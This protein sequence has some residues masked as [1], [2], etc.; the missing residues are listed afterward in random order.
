MSG[1]S[2]PPHEEPI[3]TTVDQQSSHEDRILALTQ[4]ALELKKKISAE[5]QRLKKARSKIPTP[6]SITVTTATPPHSS[7]AP[8]TIPGVGSVHR[9]ARLAEEARRKGEAAT[10]IQAL[11]RGY[12]VRR[13]LGGASLGRVG[14]GEEET[15]RPNGVLKSPSVPLINGVL[16]SPKVDLKTPSQSV[17]VQTSS[18]PLHLKPTPTAAPTATEVSGKKDIKSDDSSLEPK[19]YSLV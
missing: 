3:Q 12:K 15:V 17:G 4:S 11:F 6:I 2:P 8:P 19:H 7:V 16:K 5:A 10:R 18:S 14:D 13:G 9:Q 1:T